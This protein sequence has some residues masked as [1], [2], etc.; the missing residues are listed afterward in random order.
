PST[1]RTAGRSRSAARAWPASRGR[2]WRPSA[3][4]RSASSSSSTSCCPTSPRS[5]TSSSPAASPGESRESSWPAPSASSPR[6]ASPTGNLDPASGDQ[7]FDLLL[8]LQQRH[9]TT[10]L[11]V[12][13]NP[14]IALRCARTLRLEGGVL[15]GQQP[16]L[17]D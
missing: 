2:A 9:G 13:H 5:K 16:G 12:T 10:G 11:L 15:L 1:S 3:I 7:V 17:F 14:Q 8:D 6:P 4:V